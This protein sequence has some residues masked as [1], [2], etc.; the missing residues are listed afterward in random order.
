MKEVIAGP[1][2]GSLLCCVYVLHAIFDYGINKSH[3]RKLPLALEQTHGCGAHGVDIAKSV[4]LR[5][6]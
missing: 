5:S 1:D 6:Y 3:G 2:A 4:A